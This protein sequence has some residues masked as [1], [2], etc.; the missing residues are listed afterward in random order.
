M[1]RREPPSDQPTLGGGFRN[2][3]YG[4]EKGQTITE[5]IEVAKQYDLTTPGKYTIRV[6]QRDFD[7][8]IDV[9]LSNTI[10][11]TVTPVAP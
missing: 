1:L 3:L 9:P 8:N 7:A 2:N 6:Y 4:V 10:T 11:L 5:K